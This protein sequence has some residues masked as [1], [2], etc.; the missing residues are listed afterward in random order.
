MMQKIAPNFAV[1]AIPTSDDSK[2]MPTLKNTLK[3]Y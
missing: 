2:E 1:K 3:S